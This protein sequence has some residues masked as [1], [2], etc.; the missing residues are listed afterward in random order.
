M[1]SMPVGLYEHLMTDELGQRLAT[2]D[3]D[4][5]QLGDLN[6]AEA[7]ETLTRHLPD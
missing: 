6:P 5:V 3:D 4:L 1:G 2:T 7:H